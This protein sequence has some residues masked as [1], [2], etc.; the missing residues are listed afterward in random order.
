[1]SARCRKCPDA[2]PPWR[3]VGEVAAKLTESA[4]QATIAQCLERASEGDCD[5]FDQADQ[6]RRRL[7]LTW[8]NMLAR[9]A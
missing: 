4:G 6:I 3:A 1:M 9:A 5:A 7:G 2:P 8:E